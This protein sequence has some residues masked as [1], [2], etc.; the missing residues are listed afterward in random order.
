ME[1]FFWLA[2]WTLE[3][4]ARY[5]YIW[6]II[7]PYNL[8]LIIVTYYVD[9]IMIFKQFFTLHAETWSFLKLKPH[10]NFSHFHSCLV[11]IRASR[12]SALAEEF[13]GFDAYRLN[14]WPWA[15]TYNWTFSTLKKSWLVNISSLM[16]NVLNCMP[17]NFD[18]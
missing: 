2:V 12:D 10:S 8:I 11:R 16:D 3:K 4:Q 7:I 6:N 18:F 15:S 13:N 9:S 14:D 1:N 5:T 17:S